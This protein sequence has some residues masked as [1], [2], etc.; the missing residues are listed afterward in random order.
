MKLILRLLLIVIAT[1]L[2]S[3][4]LPWWSVFLIAFVIGFFIPGGNFNVFISGFLGAGLL[5]MIY[6][7]YLD[8]KTNSILSEKV[9]LL[10]PFNDKILLIITAG[11]IGA[12]S[13]GFGALTGNS[14]RQLFIKKKPKSFYN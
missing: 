13:G 14:F 8:I 9:V 3:F 1:Y 6:A 11:I 4:Y 5:W 10:F 2:I 7:W 12:L